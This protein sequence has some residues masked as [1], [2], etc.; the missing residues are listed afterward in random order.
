MVDEAKFTCASIPDLHGAIGTG[1]GDTSTIGRPCYGSDFMA[2]ARISIDAALRSEERGKKIGTTILEWFPD[3]YSTVI[4]A[5]GDRGTVGRPCQ[6]SD[7]FAMLVKGKE[8]TTSGDFPDQHYFIDACGGDTAAIG[9]PRYSGD[10]ADV[11]VEDEER[12]FRGGIP[13]THASIIAG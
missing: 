10:F 2:V 4:A 12:I 8:N 6:A 13:D 5:R 3:V 9:R 11:F 1:R 7:L